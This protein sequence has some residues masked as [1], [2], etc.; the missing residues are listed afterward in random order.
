MPH[1]ESMVKVQ[2]GKMEKTL[3]ANAIAAYPVRLALRNFLNDISLYLADHGYT[4]D[5]LSL[6]STSELSNG[7]KKVD[8]G[9]YKSLVFSRTF[10]MM[11]SKPAKYLKDSRDDKLHTP[12]YAM[13]QV[14]QPLSF[15]APGICCTYSERF[16][17]ND[18]ST[19][20]CCCAILEK[21]DTF[22]VKHGY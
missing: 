13:D 12:Q 15:F 11:A 21:K 9:L 22:S 10:L 20:S 2:K 17:C 7:E 19:P 3:N 1:S 6:V 16:W 18:L 5:Y 8:L 4:L 14:L